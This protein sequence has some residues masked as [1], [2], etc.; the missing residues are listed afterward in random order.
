MN[1][2]VGTC[3]GTAQ[4]R[5]PLPLCGT[6]ALRV[7]AAYAEANLGS[8]PQGSELARQTKAR[9]E[10]GILYRILDTDGWN[11]VDLNRAMQVLN[12]PKATAARRLAEA[13]RQYAGELNRRARRQSIDIDN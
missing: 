13:R 2:S 6:C 12:R 11:R 10:V 9:S 3:T 7:I 1:C 8:E 4:V 5:E